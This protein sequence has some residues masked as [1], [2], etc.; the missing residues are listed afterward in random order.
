MELE[1]LLEIAHEKIENDMDEKELKWIEKNMEAFRLIENSKHCKKCKS[2]RGHHH[3]NLVNAGGDGKRVCK[4]VAVQQWLEFLCATKDTLAEFQGFSRQTRNVIALFHQSGLAY[5]DLQGY[6]RLLFPAEEPLA[7]WIA[8]NQFDE[9]LGAFNAFHDEE[10]GTYS[11]CF[12]P[13][14][15]STY[16]DARGLNFDV[17]GFCNMSRWIQDTFGVE[18]SDEEIR[19]KS[20]Q[21]IFLMIQQ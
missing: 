17:L 11:G 13:I 3:P 4:Y 8:Q 16:L 12:G 1:C 10:Y 14:S 15:E 7:I 2:E 19:D 18:V 21:D 20:L 6:F 5:P 9:F